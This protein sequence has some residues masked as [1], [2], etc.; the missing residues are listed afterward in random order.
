MAAPAHELSAA[1]KSFD[2]LKV[3]DEFRRNPYPAYKFLRDEAP[4]SRN[5]D[6]TYVVTRFDDVA[7]VLGSADTSTDKSA[8]LR[9]SMGEGPILEFQ[10][11]AMTTWDPPRHTRIRRS[12]AHAFTPRA[13]TQWA[14]LVDE[15]VSEL[16]HEAEAKGTFDLVNDFAAALP[17]ILICKMLGVTSQERNRFRSWANSITSSLD[18]VVSPKVIEDA[19]RHAEEWKA[20]FRGLIAQRR[21][22][23]G[24]DLIS[25]LLKTEETEEPFSELALLHNL[26]LLLSAGHETTTALISSAVDVL[27]QYPDQ[28]AR[29]RSDPELFDSAVEEFLRFESPVQMGARRTTGPIKLSGGTV[30]A[31]ELIWTIQGAANR[32]ER[33]FREPDRLDVGRKPNRQLA[34]ATGIHVCLGA[35]LA[36]LEARVAMQRLVC[37]YP[38][39]RQAG[40]PTR[41]LRTRYRG[42]SNYPL[43][44]K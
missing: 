20:F 16:L 33:Q 6:G 39:M 30:P 31:G 18:P 10:L 21:K 13:M 8:E 26:A 42:F 9:R 12:L 11:S 34:F 32:D 5:S 36:R 35:P 25:L 3:D 19:N 2:L 41:N 24:N 15:A 43:S 27:F 14:P 23:P 44:L 37:D 17:L 29:L 1:I 4:L 28:A 40:A 7:D 38:N 22:Q